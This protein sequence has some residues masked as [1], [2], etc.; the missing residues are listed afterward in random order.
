MQLNAEKNELTKIPDLSKFNSIRDVILTFNQIGSVPTGSFNF[1]SKSNFSIDLSN[2]QIVSISSE[3]FDFPNAPEVNIILLKNQITSIPLGLIKSYAVQA[4]IYIGLAYNN[5]SSISSGSFNYP[6][7]KT[8]A[9]DLSNNQI[10]TIEPGSF[11]GT[12]FCNV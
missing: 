7:A 2:N 5:I 6:Q 1:T 11:K 12:I 3:A 4:S 9:L 8:V 10:S